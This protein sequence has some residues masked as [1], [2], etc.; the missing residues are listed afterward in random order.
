MLSTQRPL[1][2]FLQRHFRLELLV[3]FGERRFFITVDLSNEQT[4]KRNLPSSPLPN[5][6]KVA[7]QMRFAALERRPADAY[8]LVSRLN[9]PADGSLTIASRRE[10]NHH[11]IVIQH[12]TGDPTTGISLVK[13]IPDGAT[14]SSATLTGKEV[15]V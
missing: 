15:E 10:D 2:S 9:P 3:P 13:R 11:F 6:P 14:E 5:E 4:Q 12:S 1:P 7:V 8:L